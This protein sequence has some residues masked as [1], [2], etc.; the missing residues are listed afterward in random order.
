MAQRRQICPLNNLPT[1]VGS[2]FYFVDMIRSTPQ[3]GMAC[4]VPAAVDPMAPPNLCSPMERATYEA[5]LDCLRLYFTREERFGERD[6]KLPEEIEI[7]D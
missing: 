4:M 5:A 1:V 7:L 6:E 3:P 2:A